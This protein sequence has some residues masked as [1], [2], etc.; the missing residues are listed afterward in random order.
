[1]S[2]RYI[3][4]GG[5]A[6]NSTNQS[7]PTE[8]L[9]AR[10]L[11]S[12]TISHYIDANQ[13]ELTMPVF[14]AYITALCKARGEPPER[15]IKRAC[16]ERCFGHQLFRGDRKPSRDTVLQLAF[17]FEADIEH[18]QTLLKFAQCCELYPRDKRDAVIIYGLFHRC[19]VVQTQ[20]MLAD[21]GYRLLGEV[22]RSRM[23]KHIEE[24]EQESAE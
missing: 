19:S 8:M 14:P 3:A 12:P 18:A 22:K 1:M 21:A 16:I 2:S 11:E 13:T 17:G 15:V 10:L 9:W 23:T 4:L 6:L 5:F 7:L 20:N 24:T